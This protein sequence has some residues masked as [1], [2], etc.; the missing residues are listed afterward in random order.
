MYSSNGRTCIGGR[1]ERAWRGVDGSELISA[2]ISIAGL[3]VDRSKKKASFA[4]LQKDF[5][6]TLSQIILHRQQVEKLIDDLTDWLDSPVTILVDLCGDTKDQSLKIYIG[7]PDPRE[8]LEKTIFE[9]Q[10]LGTAFEGKWSFGIDQS[11]V[12]L[13]ADEMRLALGKLGRSS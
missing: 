2:E 4:T 13:F 8:R 10:Y 5:V 12:R 6:A 11:C 7:P 1:F 9:V 3:W